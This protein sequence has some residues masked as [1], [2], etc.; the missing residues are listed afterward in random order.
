MFLRHALT[1]RRVGGRPPA[2]E[3]DGSFNTG[4]HP[5]EYESVTSC[6]ATSNEEI[7][8]TVGFE[9]VL[10]L[11]DHR[12][13]KQRCTPITKQG[14]DVGAG[15]AVMRAL[16]PAVVWTVMFLEQGLCAEEK[17]N[18][19]F[20]WKRPSYVMP[21]LKGMLLVGISQSSIGPV[22]SAS[23]NDGR[24]IPNP[25]HFTG[26]NGDQKCISLEKIG[27]NVCAVQEVTGSGRHYYS[28]CMLYESRKICGKPTFVRYHCC[29]GY[30]ATG[31]DP[32]KCD[33]VKPMEHLMGTAKHLYLRDLHKNAKRSGVNKRLIREGPY[34]WF[35]P[36][37]NAFR[38]IPRDITKQMA[39]KNQKKNLILYHTVSGR[40]YSK[41][42]KNGMELPTLYEGNPKIRVNKYGNGITTVN[43]A[44]IIL[45][46][47]IA[48]NGILHVTDKVISPIKTEG[49]TITELLLRDGKFGELVTALIVTGL[50]N[51]LREEGPFTIFAPTDAAFRK[52]PQ[53][54]VDRILNN[55]EVLMKLLRYHVIERDLCSAA[56][57]SPTKITTREGQ[58]LEVSCDVSDRL[59]INGASASETDILASNGIIHA[60]DDLLIPDSAR[61]VKETLTKL[62]LSRFLEYS[63]AAGLTD[64]V[65]GT[66]REGYT[67]FIP[68]DEA[69]RNLTPEQN[70]IL[71]AQPAMV[72]K[73]FQYH[74]VK[75]NMSTR[76]L[77]GE[78]AVKS[79]N[80]D[81]KV[82]IHVNV[83][84]KGFGVNSARIL[85]SDQVAGQSV[86]HVVDKVMFPPE[87]SSMENIRQDASLS[88]FR[89]LLRTAG[90]ERLLMATDGA[91][92]VFA[93]T[94]DALEALRGTF[95]DQLVA[96]KAEL[97]KF[98]GYHIL[99][100]P[101][102]MSGVRS[103]LR[104]R[105]KTQ[106]KEW[107]SL[108]QIATGEPIVIDGKAKIIRPD[109][110]TTNGVMHITDTALVCPCLKNKL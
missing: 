7:V 66:A 102:Y 89:S 42:L 85:Q 53:E 69:F 72:R 43:C 105:F 94:N 47:Q 80:A 20:V 1:G 76:Q 56:I 50:G 28:E 92:T 96:N 36:E 51:D 99:R 26:T 87:A 48:T 86:V 58:T 77:V 75:G 19:R 83:Q 30:E 65:D 100:R 44:R 16:I 93:P 22:L 91:Y 101:I 37:N 81:V 49:S 2:A 71:R 18:T 12:L 57:I 79:Y 3:G 67:L 107:L 63:Q 34:T 46:D 41:D 73:V 32:H 88:T 62:G 61:S 40:Y 108:R 54:V 5:R 4:F 45:P 31:E 90:M 21:W 15:A 55:K 109:V 35:A 17:K 106:A 110:E 33:G 84:Q 13:G 78:A 8:S 14:R 74:V 23:T 27:P 39:V 98:L 9:E 70:H 24:C 104:Y 95:L 52:A 59:T 60:I 29:T 64:I 97:K 10:L 68:N 6:V 25:F 103:D 38:G 11:V 82:K